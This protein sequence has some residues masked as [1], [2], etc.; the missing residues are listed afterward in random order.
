MKKNIKNRSHSLVPVTLIGVV[1]P[2]TKSTGDGVSGY[3]LACGVGVEYL[4][5]VDSE[6]RQ[7]LSR[8]C[9]EDVKVKGLLDLSNLTLIPQRVFPRGPTGESY[10]VID[11]A[12]SK[13]RDL[14]N[15]IGKNLGLVLAAPFCWAANTGA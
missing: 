2:M 9:W 13:G 7:V 1:V 12:A 5:M 8:Y 14:G 6:W 10:N 3:K 11:I 4:I 15:K